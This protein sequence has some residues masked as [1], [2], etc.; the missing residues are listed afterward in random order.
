LVALLWL[1][2][3]RVLLPSILLVVALAGSASAS[4]IEYDIV[5]SGDPDAP[6]FSGIFAT[7]EDDEKRGKK[8]G[9]DGLRILSRDLSGLLALSTDAPELFLDDQELRVDV[10]SLSGSI[11][12]CERCEERAIAVELDSRFASILE[13]DDGALE[14]LIH[15]LLTLDGTT[16]EVVLSARGRTAGE[17]ANS[18]TPEAVSLLLALA[19]D[20]DDDGKK[21]RLD[22]WERGTLRSFGAY[23]EQGHGSSHYRDRPDHFD[24]DVEIFL[25]AQGPVVPEPGSFFLLAGGLLALALASRRGGLHPRAAASG[26]ARR[27]SRGV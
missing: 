24:D 22:S 11:Q 13:V 17:E 26:A 15:L 1:L 27:A 9:G 8:D 18:A 4:R 16:E 21:Q 6:P 3:N 12:L 25:Q 7:S 10:F 14:G 2:R 23:G 5:S 20:L 19:L